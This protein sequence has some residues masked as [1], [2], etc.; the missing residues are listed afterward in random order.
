MSAERKEI[1]KLINEA[2]DS[3]AR[4]DKA[5]EIVGLSAK[6][7]QRWAHSDNEQDK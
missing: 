1:V 2:R 7:F 5:C 3:G 6:T 4:Q